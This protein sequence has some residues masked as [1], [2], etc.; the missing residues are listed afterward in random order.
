L[1]RPLPLRGELNEK[2][3]ERKKKNF[4]LSEMGKQKAE[5]R[6]VFSAKSKPFL[7]GWWGDK[8]KL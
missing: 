2:K 1:E 6:I 8:K 7:I 4:P 3:G 5:G